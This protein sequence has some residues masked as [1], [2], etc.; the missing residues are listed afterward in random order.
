MIIGKNVKKKVKKR[1]RGDIMPLDYRLVCYAITGDKFSLGIRYDNGNGEHL[2][3]FT[4]VE[5]LENLNRRKG[6]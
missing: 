4:N 5:D 1:Q 3:D 2:A 6:K